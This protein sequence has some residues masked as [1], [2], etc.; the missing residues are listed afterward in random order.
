MRI[1]KNNKFA[2]ISDVYDYFLKKKNIL[3]EGIFLK[4]ND[5][6]VLGTPKELIKYSSLFYEKKRFCFDLDNT[7]VTFPKKKGDYST[8][9]PIYH[10]I[11]YLNFLKEKGHY[12][13]IFTARRMKTFN[14]NIK[15]VIKNIKKITLKQLQKFNIKYDELIFGKPYADF[16]IDDLAINSRDNINFNLGFYEENENLSRVNNDILIGERVTKKTSQNKKIQFEAKYLSSLPEDLKNYFPNTHVIGKDYYTMDTVHGVDFNTLAE[17]NLLEKK[18]LTQLLNVLKI[19]HNKKVPHETLSNYNP[20][21]YKNYLT[22][23]LDRKK[24]LDKDII[25]KYDFFFNKIEDDL[26]KNEK[27][28]ISKNWDYSRRPNFF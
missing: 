27:K 11:R 13:I 28:K 25:L 12:I 21:Y 6:F 26:R 14:G 19:M 4:K 23:F 9:D 15:K 10:N 24:F 8:C 7:L 5:F 22:K 18:H 20:L 3:I 2:F 17:L 1:V 16:Y